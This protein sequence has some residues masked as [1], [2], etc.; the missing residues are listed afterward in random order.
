MGYLSS[1]MCEIDSVLNEGVSSQYAITLV[2]LLVLSAY[3]RGTS[4]SQWTL[5]A[6]AATM[7]RANLMEVVDREWWRAV[8]ATPQRRRVRRPSPP[9][10]SE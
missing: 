7:R 10:S 4:C 9:S 8:F 2:P 5:T 1:S 3:M 6:S